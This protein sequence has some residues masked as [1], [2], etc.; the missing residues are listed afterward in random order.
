MKKFLVF[1]CGSELGLDLY[2]SVCYST[3]QIGH[4][5]INIRRIFSLTLCNVTTM[6][7]LSWINI[8][9]MLK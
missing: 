4:W 5:R 8:Q 1:P 6:I 9:L 3:C 7:A 2:S